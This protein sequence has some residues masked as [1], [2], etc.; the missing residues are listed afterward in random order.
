MATYTGTEFH[1][2]AG[3][4]HYISTAA[5]YENNGAGIAF[6]SL[7]VF[8]NAVGPETPEAQL[9][10]LTVDLVNGT[11]TND[12]GLEATLEGWFEKI[13]L[14]G[15]DDAVVGDEKDQVFSGGDGAD[16]FEGGGGNDTLSYKYETTQFGV[17]VDIAGGRARDPYGNIDTFSNISNI[18]GTVHA[19][20]LLGDENANV[21]NF[22]GGGQFNTTVD[23]FFNG[24]NLADG[25]G[26]I[27]TV[28]YSEHSFFGSPST[29]DLSKG[30]AIHDDGVADLLINI[31]NVVGSRYQETIIGDDQDN[32][33]NGVYGRD[34]L[35]G[36]GGEDR[37]HVHTGD[38]FLI[39]GPT[40]T[41]DGG[42][43]YD[44]LVA[45]AADWEN[46]AGLSW[47]IKASGSATFY[48]G[49][50]N[51]VDSFVATD[52]E[53]I[54][55]ADRTVDL[56]A[57]PTASDVEH[58]RFYDAA[59]GEHAW[60]SDRD[61]ITTWMKEEETQPELFEGNAFG[62]YAA[63]TAGT[64]AIELDDEVAYVLASQAEGTIAL[65]VFEKPD[66]DLFYTAGE[67]EKD[68]ILTGIPSFEYQGVIGYVEGA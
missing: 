48:S 43:G 39:N 28:D 8:G 52:F 22:V 63:G 58:Y 16:A 25:R 41:A 49:N 2:T 37:I 3:N 57:G 62:T 1:A 7:H 36:N 20:F 26:G 24:G 51:G 53:E 6:S 21:F 17:I 65:H 14:T 31:E 29:I 11:I 32:E 64:T 5:A 35:F 67:G 12:Q 34:S 54:Q 46:D 10:G 60:T 47:Q 59:T 23:P 45:T 66:G 38:T 15:F 33:I 68:I 9:A 19:D 42:S 56:L 50:P 44:V 40:V 30:T 13:Y 4:D 55:F 61:G 18:I 27:D